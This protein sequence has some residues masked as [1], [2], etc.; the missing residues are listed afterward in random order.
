MFFKFCIKGF[1]AEMAVFIVQEA[2]TVTQENPFKSPGAKVYELIREN[3]PVEGLCIALPDI[4][5]LP[6]NARYRRLLYGP[7]VTV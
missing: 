1:D 6:Y 3:L 5:S 2:K 7:K 4:D